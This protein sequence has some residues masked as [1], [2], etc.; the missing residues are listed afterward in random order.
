MKKNLLISFILAIVLQSILI[1]APRIGLAADI[2]SYSNMQAAIVP[3]VFVVTGNGSYCTGG[4]GVAVG[5]RGSEAGVSYTLYKNHQLIHPVGIVVLGT[6]SAITFGNQLAGTY[7]VQAKQGDDIT[8]MTG[9]AI[10][11]ENSYPVITTPVDQIECN[12]YTLPMISGTAK[13]YNNTQ[14]NGGVLITGPI[15]ST[16]TVW[17]YDTNGSCITEVSFLVT[18]STMADAPAPV[19]ACYSYTLPALTNGNYFTGAAGKGTALVAGDVISS[20][21]LLYVYTPAIS[22]CVAAA[23]NSFV[24]TV[25]PAPTITG[26]VDASL[27]PVTLSNGNTPGQVYTT[28]PGMTEYVWAVSGGNSFTYGKDPLGAVDPSKIF[29]DWVNVKGQQSVSVTYSNGTC[30]AI[31]PTV[32]IIN[33]FPFLPAIDPTIIPQF[34]D[35]LPHF[36]AG[37]RVNAKAGGNLIVKA[38]PVQQIA[39]ST[40]T[41]LATGTIGKATPL[42]GM[43]QYA[44]YQ[45]SKDGGSSFG[46]AMWPAQTIEAQ[47]GNQLTV[48]YENHLSG[49]TYADF[50]ILTDQTLMMNGYPKTGNVLTDPYTGPIPMVVH[51]HGGEMPSGSDGGPTGWFMPGYS[52]Y[53]PGFANG[54]SSLSTYPN[55]QEATTLWYH[56]HDQG[57]TRIN[58]YTGLAGFYFLRGETEETAKLP[59]WSG[60]NKV[61][62]VNPTDSIKTPIFKG[63]RTPTFNGT[64]TYLPEIELGIQDRMFNVN[65]ELYWPVRPPNPDIH[66]FWGPEFFG[67]VMTVNGK[68]W[69]YLSAAP[70]KYR[71][72]ILNGCNARFLNVWLMDLATKTNGPS[73][74]VIGS[75]GGLLD[76]PAI[77]NPALGQTLTIGPGERYDVVIDFTGIASGTVFTLMNDGGSPHPDGDPVIEGLTDRIMQFVVNGNMVSATEGTPTDKS[78]LPDN[79]RTA[80][81]MVKLTDFAGNLTP[82]VTP[83]VKR[84]IIL[85][86]VSGAGGPVQVLFNNSHF[87]ANILMPGSPTEFGG[88]TELPHEGSTEQFTLIN[89]TVDAHPIH[90]HLVQWQLVNRQTFNKV[91]YAAAYSAAWAPKG[92]S[93]WPVGQGYP[94]G[95]GSPFDYNTV[96]GDGAVGGNPAITPF[97]TGSIIPAKP[98][99]MGWKDNIV[100]L[101]GQIST[102]IVRFAP[103]DL[104]INAKKNELQFSFDPSVGPGYVWHCHII[105]HEDMDMM[106]PLM[107]QPSPIRTGE[108]G[109]LGDVNGDFKTNSTDALIILSCEARQDVSQFCPMNFADTNVDALINSTD[110]LII[111]SYDTK[112]NVPK[113]VGEFVPPVIAA[114]CEG[115]K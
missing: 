60:D 40:G 65:G 81:P 43:G 7:T 57:L 51:L 96:N 49:K 83:A 22:P 88:P 106:R 59:G 89:T 91:R 20:T 8:D 84:Q 29:V 101:P 44:A 92:L 115:C 56:P 69:P 76:A 46:P 10:I 61:Q 85:N 100:I 77:L 75:D 97:L 73:I 90:I 13:Y 1:F 15:T 48:K 14:A 58:V 35:P 24:I 102:Y 113:S 70:R 19:T 86:E 31:A 82:G 33:Y 54:S 68:A 45:I 110:A 37:L 32:L 103:T 16:Q 112:L 74:S 26:P 12:S 98:Q 21:T 95:A 25:I 55:K 93:E 107:V 78:L 109:M 104:P 4:E 50:N 94:G 28:E 42:V 67:D 71:F 99:E 53:G 63:T 64:N 18:I 80:N 41:V 108:L 66:P 6:G 11:T 87:D 38:V 9:N 2:S 23:E 30:A 105:D 17:I 34:V 47:Q 39:L 5:L 62:E 3:N 111:L 79:L 72:R 36:A 52:L 27:M 114:P